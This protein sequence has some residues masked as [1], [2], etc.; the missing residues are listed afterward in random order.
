MQDVMLEDIDRIEVISGPGG[1]LWGVNAVNGVINI[2]TRSAKDTQGDLVAVEGGNQGADTAFRHG[3][4]LGDGGSFRVYGKYFERDHTSKANGDPVNDALHRSQAGFRADWNRP[5]D[6]VMVHGNVYDGNEGQPEPG[7]I[8][9]SGVNPVLG[10]VSSF[11]ANLTARWEHLLDNGSN[12]GFQ[13]YYDRTERTAPPMYKESL[14]II[15][16]QLQHSLRPIGRHTLTWGANYRYGMNRIENTG[17][18]VAFLPAH[19]NQKWASLFAQDEIALRDNLRLTLG[20]RIE[21]NDYTGNEF[22]PNAR[23]AWKLA[24]DHLLWGA[25]SRTVRAPS[26]VDADTYLYRSALYPGPPAPGATPFV[27]NGGPEVRSEVARVYEIGYR[28]QPAPRLSYSITAFHTDYDDLRTQEI[29]LGGAPTLDPAYV[30]LTYANA[31]AGKTDGIETWGSYQASPRWRLSAGFTALKERLWLKPGSS[32]TAAPNAAGNDPAYS[33]Q[34]R[35]SSNISR[36]QELDFTVRHVASLENMDVPAYTA[37]DARFGWKLRH[38]L[39]LSVI[40]QNL[41]GHHA[42]YGSSLYRSDLSPAVYVKL[43]WQG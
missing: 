8:A 10:N 24:P 39:E 14:D 11:G 20:A 17:A 43:L 21:R 26:R 28:G 35:S 36:S 30:F 40:G 5:G 27:L 29:N 12:I 38:G 19:V 4:M 25:V 18:Y 2:L 7:Q 42:E 13:A 22:L 16:L 1:T 23:L 3:G 34:L 6:Q 9:I 31:M 37:V 41:F 32:D 15:D 33:W